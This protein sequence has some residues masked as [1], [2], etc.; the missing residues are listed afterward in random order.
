[1]KFGYINSLAKIDIELQI[2]G[3]KDNFSCERFFVEDGTQSRSRSEL[4]RLLTNLRVGDTLCLYTIKCLPISTIELIDFIDNITRNKMVEIKTMDGGN[5]HWEDFSVL[6]DFKRHFRRE[7]AMVGLTSARARGRSGGR[8]EGLSED[9]KIT[10]N[11]AAKLYQAKT[12][13]NDILKTLGIG[14]KATLYR[15]LRFEGIEI[16]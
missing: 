15:Y 9:A 16:S 3:L 1:M 8:K 4:D 10:A 14:S 5:I 11:A 6:A 12:P 13:I 7:R 2:Q